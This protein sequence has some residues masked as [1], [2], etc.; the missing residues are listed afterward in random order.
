VK[1]WAISAIK[2]TDLTSALVS[3]VL[4]QTAILSFTTQGDMSY[5]NGISGMLFGG[6][7]TLIGIYM[8]IRA[9]LIKRQE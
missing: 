3:L 4:T 2:L 1:N 8:M 9:A 7:A 5:F 6:I